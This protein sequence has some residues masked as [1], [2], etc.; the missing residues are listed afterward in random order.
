MNTEKSEFKDY[1]P[2]FFLPPNRHFPKKK[3][4]N[5]EINSSLPYNGHRIKVIHA[6]HTYLLC[7]LIGFSFALYT[8]LKIAYISESLG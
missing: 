8:T 1:F 5:P 6:S 2:F 7:I 4:V 3:S